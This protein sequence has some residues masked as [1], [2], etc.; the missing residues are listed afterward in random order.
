MDLSAEKTSVSLEKVTII[1][2]L[3]NFTG[4]GIRRRKLKILEANDNYFYHRMD[5]FRVLN[6]GFPY[7]FQRA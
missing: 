6:Y 7:H 1:Y 4:F 2:K 5:A 3:R